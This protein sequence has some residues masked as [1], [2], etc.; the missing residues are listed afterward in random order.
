MFEQNNN[1][2]KNKK[3]NN[4]SINSFSTNK[5]SFNNSNN[6]HLNSNNQ[7]FDKLQTTFKNLKLNNLDEKYKENSKNKNENMKGIYKTSKNIQIKKPIDIKDSCAFKKNLVNEFQNLTKENLQIFSQSIDSNP[8][9]YT[10]EIPKDLKNILRNNNIR[11]NNLLVNNDENVSSNQNNKYQNSFNFNNYKNKTIND[12]TNNFRNDSIKNNKI[13]L[14]YQ[15]RPRD[16]SKENDFDKNVNTIDKQKDNKLYN[17]NGNINQNEIRNVSKNKTINENNK[18]LYMTKNKS[19]NN[20]LKNQNYLAGNIIREKKTKK[21]VASTKKNNL[22]NKNNNENLLTK[23]N[24]NLYE[25]RKLEPGKIF[26]PNHSLGEKD[27]R[28]GQ[29][30]NN[31]NITVMNEI[32]NKEKKQILN[33]ENYFKNKIEKN[34]SEIDSKSYRTKESLEKKLPFEIYDSIEIEKNYASN[35]NNIKIS[36]NYLTELKFKK[37]NFNENANLEHTSTFNFKDKKIEELNEEIN[38]TL[39]SAVENSEIKYKSESNIEKTNRKMRAEDI[40]YSIKTSTNSEEN[41]DYEKDDIEDMNT[42]IRQL[43]FDV[44]VSKERDIFGLSNKFYNIF[45]D[46]FNNEIDPYLF[47]K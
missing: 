45:T 17:S 25:S 5:T 43:D 35:N 36:E 11:N 26:K 19:I 32:L 39:K 10:K 9:D 27:L 31:K 18:M 22:I 16:F 44:K 15:S 7:K 30:K 34:L 47:H 33:Q 38:S 4:K 24:H 6:D 40:F 13:S 3:S 42:I 1:L 29:N 23:L 41:L 12:N 14:N 8:M 21:N 37:D 2:I 46:K 20:Y 28:K